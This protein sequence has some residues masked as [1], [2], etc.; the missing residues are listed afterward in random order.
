[1]GQLLTGVLE[2]PTNNVAP[3]VKTKGQISVGADPLG[4]V[5]VHDSL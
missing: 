2:L 1:M 3:L 4:V 5:R